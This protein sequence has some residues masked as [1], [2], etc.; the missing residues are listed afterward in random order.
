MVTLLNIKFFP[1]SSASL[2]SSPVQQPLNRIGMSSTIYLI[3]SSEVLILTTQAIIVINMSLI[4]L[5]CQWSEWKKVGQCS[6]S[7]GT[8][9]QKFQRTIQVSSQ[10]GGKS[11]V[12]ESTKTETCNSHAC[13]GRYIKTRHCI[14]GTII[15]K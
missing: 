8:G 7:C 4:F 10:N 12:G 14:L 5:D 15:F 11:C 13:Q 9:T 3:N 2:A 1:E 6:K